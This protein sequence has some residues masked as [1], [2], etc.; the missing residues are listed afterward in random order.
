MLPLRLAALASSMVLLG[1][2]TPTLSANDAQVT[3][4]NFTFSPSK[5]TVPAGTRVVWINRDDIPHT[6]VENGDRRVLKSEPLD[7]GDSFSF[8]FSS[9]GTYSYFCSIHPRMQGTVVVE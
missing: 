1:A 4:D 5:V 9:P 6:V 3:I 7:T 2:S 8:V